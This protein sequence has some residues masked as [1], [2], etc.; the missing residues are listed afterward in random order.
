MYSSSNP[1]FSFR[2]NQQDKPLLVV[3]WD[4]VFDYYSVYGIPSTGPAEVWSGAKL[5]RATKPG[6]KYPVFRES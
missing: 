5:S 1:K 3:Q 2:N 4:P 6:K